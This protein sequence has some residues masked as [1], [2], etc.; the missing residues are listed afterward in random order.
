[1]IISLKKKGIRVFHFN[2]FNEQPIKYTTP[3]LDQ[4]NNQTEIIAHFYSALIFLSFCE[5]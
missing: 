1:M 3:Q 2:T 5:E 4:L